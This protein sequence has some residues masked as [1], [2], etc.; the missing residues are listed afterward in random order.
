MVT[1]P[2]AS[3]L[4]T[5]APHAL[6]GLDAADA[7]SSLRT[8]VVELVDN[9]IDACQGSEAGRIDVSLEP[10]DAA[11]SRWMV[12]VTDD[13]RGFSS[14]ALSASATE[15][16]VGSK[17][18]GATQRD[19]GNLDLSARGASASTGA[20]GVGL[21]AVMVWAHLSSAP[22]AEEGVVEI[23][24]TTLA[25]TELSIL[26]VR[27][28][29]GSGIGTGDDGGGG[30][31]GGGLS[32]LR[33]A[34]EHGS[35][36]KPC[37]FSGT[38]VHA[39]LGGGPA[40]IDRVASYLDCASAFLSSTSLDF[41]VRLP[42]GPSRC[43]HVAAAPLEE[44]YTAEDRGS[45]PPALPG[46]RDY[47]GRW[48]DHLQHGRLQ[49]GSDHGAGDGGGDGDCGG[50]GD[51]GGGGGVLRGFGEGVAVL[52]ASSLVHATVLL[53]AIAPSSPPQ[54]PVASHS[55]SSSPPPSSA[56][57][58]CPAQTTRAF[59]NNKLL[60]EPG[61]PLSLRCASVAAFKK[62]S[63]SD[64]LGLSLQPSTLQL[65]GEKANDM[66][67][68]HI[69][70][71]LRSSAHCPLVRFGDLAKTFVLPSKPLVGAI[72]K[73]LDSALGC[74]V[75]ALAAQGCL[76]AKHDRALREDKRLAAAIATSI[77][78]IVG[79]S[80]DDALVRSCCEVLRLEEEEAIEDSAAPGG[81]DI[82]AAV[83]KHLE[84]NWSELLEPQRRDGGG[85]GGGDGGDDG[86]GGS[87]GRGGRGGGRQGGGR[88]AVRRK[89]AAPEAAARVRQDAPTVQ[90]SA[91]RGPSDTQDEWLWEPGDDEW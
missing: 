80:R 4:Q 32:L 21:K 82:A 38:V 81:A 7:A 1:A 18:G 91:M 60:G 67:G 30:G 5:A 40:A 70:L 20:F 79:R 58:L 69:V 74:A 62:V 35:M 28:Q 15:L 89:R 25:S 66:R 26:R 50:G 29:E 88:A 83:L 10:L 84:R 65:L 55:A 51:R 78:R 9:A 49:R 90:G 68:L 85:G 14:G 59:L 44:V 61:E 64:R 53:A 33:P 34:L 56:Q 87:G 16:F 41:S 27:L 39:I 19:G 47:L 22:P 86:G 57:P 8:C 73:A 75:D 23:R 13:G 77:G 36:P 31:G 37:A 12:R 52:N 54:P 45:S 76:L 17:G 42:N 24:T 11:G 3:T 63:W 2:V 43:L 48:L 46:A 6:F 71:H 72:G